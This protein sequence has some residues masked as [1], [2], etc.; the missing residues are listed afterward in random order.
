MLY[1]PITTCLWPGQT[2]P[3][4]NT[5]VTCFLAPAGFIYALSFGFTFQQV[6]EKHRG[7]LHKVFCITL[8]MTCLCVDFLHY[9]FR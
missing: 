9:I 1:N 6:F 2:R 8:F 5:A 7:V 3:D 4:I